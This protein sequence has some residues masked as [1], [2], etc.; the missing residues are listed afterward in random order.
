MDSDHKIYAIFWVCL[1]IFLSVLVVSLASF[2]GRQHA[3]S[4]QLQE[5]YAAHCSVVNETISSDGDGSGQIS[6]ACK[7]GK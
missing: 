5:Y 1:A 6:Y 4:V 7:G 3:Q 2:S